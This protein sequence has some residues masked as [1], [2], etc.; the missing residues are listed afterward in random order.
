METIDL[1]HFENAVA[2]LHKILER[3]KR[4]NY[5]IDIVRDSLIKRFE[6]TYSTAVRLIMRYLNYTAP[7]KEEQLTFNEAIRRANQTG[8]LLNN[9]EKWSDYRQ[10]RNITSHMYDEKALDSIID[11]I[12]DFL[13][14]VD[15]LLEKL[16]EKLL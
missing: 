13:Q 4:E 6:Y 1:T 11:I 14:D 10:K 9:L 2:S 16:K 15:Y 12:P 5:D 8:L 7:E 3:Y